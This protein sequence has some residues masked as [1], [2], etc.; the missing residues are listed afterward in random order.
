MAVPANDEVIYWHDAGEILTVSA[1]GP[2]VLAPGLCSSLHAT[3]C[4]NLLA[5]AKRRDFD[6]VDFL[7]R[8]EEQLRYAIQERRAWRRAGVFI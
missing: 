7:K 2:V 3:L 5:A 4:G 1:E 6:V 8:Q